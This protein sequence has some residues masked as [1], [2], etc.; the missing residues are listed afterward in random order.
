MLWKLTVA[1]CRCLPKPSDCKKKKTHLAVKPELNSPAWRQRG[2][3]STWR[4]GAPFSP[5]SM[6][7][8]LFGIVYLRPPEDKTQ[9]GTCYCCQDGA[10]PPSSSPRYDLG[11]KIIH[12]SHCLFLG[13]VWQI[14]ANQVNISYCVLAYFRMQ[15]SDHTKNTVHWRSFVT[16]QRFFSKMFTLEPL[17][18]S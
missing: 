14:V 13:S 7:S 16:E 2:L 8:W 18:A 5:S 3:R 10:P 17:L 1:P 12:F 9:C 15:A 11:C 4:F 6:V